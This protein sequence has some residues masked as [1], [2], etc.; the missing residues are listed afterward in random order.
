LRFQIQPPLTPDENSLMPETEE[1][2]AKQGFEGSDPI[3]IGEG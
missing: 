3:T 1:K 2:L